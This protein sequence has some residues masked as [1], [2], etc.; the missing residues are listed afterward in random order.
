MM[1][2]ECYLEFHRV[3]GEGPVCHHCDVVFDPLAQ[4]LER[5]LVLHPLDIY[6]LIG[7]DSDYLQISTFQ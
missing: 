6:V 4:V 5:V 7:G 2:L 1:S 3:I